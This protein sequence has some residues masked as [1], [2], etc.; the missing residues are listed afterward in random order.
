LP[1]N[2]E[3]AHE[4]RIIHRDLKPANVKVRPDGVVKVLL[5]APRAIDEGWN[6]RA[7]S[8]GGWTVPR[9]VRRSRCS[10]LPPGISSSRVCG[11]PPGAPAPITRF[12]VLPPDPDAALTLTF[13]PAV[14]LAANG[15]AAAFVAAWRGAD[16]VYVR[17]RADAVARV[18]AG[19]ERGT[20]AAVSPYG[21]WVVFRGRSHPQGTD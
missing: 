7:A 5:E 14:D 8:S 17:T 19:S 3:A 18:I 20:S 15:D 12:D 1:P 2:N 4:Q 16:R 6:C 21:K 11:N 10:R 9:S 13:R